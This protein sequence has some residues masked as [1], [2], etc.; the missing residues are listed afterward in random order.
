MRDL[1]EHVMTHRHL[2]P[3]FFRLV[4]GY[5]ASAQSDEAVRQ[6]LAIAGET[7]ADVEVVHVSDPAV[8]SLTPWRKEEYARHGAEDRWRGRYDWRTSKGERYRPCSWSGC[9]PRRWSPGPRI[10]GPT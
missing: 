2:D 1:A 9:L 8:A 7:G 3:V 4:V 10:D 6:A 5:D